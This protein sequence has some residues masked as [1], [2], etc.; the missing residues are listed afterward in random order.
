ML[1]VP[2]NGLRE[3]HPRRLENRRVV[4][5]VGIAAPDVEGPT[6]QQ[7]P[8]EI[9]EPRLQQALEFRVTDEIIG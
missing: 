4:G 7:H 3:V 6:R 1:L 5:A 2:D 8:R 9:A